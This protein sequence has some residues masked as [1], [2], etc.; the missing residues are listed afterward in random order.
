LHKRG[1]RRRHWFRHCWETFASIWGDE[2][3]VR[4][5]IEGLLNRSHILDWFNTLNR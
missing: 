5:E 4:I 1:S 2:T 3:K